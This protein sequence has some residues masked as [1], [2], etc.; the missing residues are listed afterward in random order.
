MSCA[1]DVQQSVAGS[2]GLNDIAVKVATRVIGHYPHRNQLMID[3]GWMALS[4][5]GHGKLPSR[6]YGVF[7]DH[8]DLRYNYDMIRYDSVYLTCS[9]KLTDSQLSLPRRMNKK[10]VKEKELKIKNKN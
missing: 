8:P 2:C 4:L 3:A 9:K 6:S 5:D 7:Q 10:N 1:S